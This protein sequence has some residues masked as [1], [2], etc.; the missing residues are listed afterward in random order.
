MNESLR[1][2]A[3]I[4]SAEKVYLL[5][6]SSKIE[7]ISLFKIVPISDIDYIITDDSIS[8]EIF[9]LY[10]DNGVEIIIAK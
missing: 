6:D 5:C 9:D 10:K 1:I 4:N 8:K 3:M 2:K 7:D